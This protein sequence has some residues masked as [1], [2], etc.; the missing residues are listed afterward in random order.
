MI[1]SAGEPRGKYRCERGK[2]VWEYSKEQ[3]LH[4]AELMFFRPGEQTVYYS[5]NKFGI[6]DY[7]K[8]HYNCHLFDSSTGKGGV[9]AQ[10]D[11]GG[12]YDEVSGVPQNDTEAIKSYTIAA[13]QGDLYSQ[14]KLGLYY[15]RSGKD[16]IKAY[17]WLTMAAEQGSNLAKKEREK[18]SKKMTPEQI[19][20]A[21]DLIKEIKSK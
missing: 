11:L 7:W 18:I 6:G 4:G 14:R 5:T 1:A 12:I 17:A 13:K 19:A 2:E 16:Y 10:K 8:S 15:K 20:A 21:N 9:D 3:V